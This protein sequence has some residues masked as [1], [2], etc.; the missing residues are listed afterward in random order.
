[1]NRLEMWGWNFMSKGVLAMQQ[2]FFEIGWRLCQQQLLETVADKGTKAAAAMKP[3]KMTES[4]ANMVMAKYK[5]TNTTTRD[6]IMAHVTGEPKTKAPSL[7][8]KKICQLINEKLVLNQR[9]YTREEIIA[10]FP[11]VRQSRLDTILATEFTKLPN[12]HYVTN[13]LD[14]LIMDMQKCIGSDLTVVNSKMLALNYTSNEIHLMIDQSDCFSV[15]DDTLFNSDS[16]T[17]KYATT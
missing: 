7:S 3:A 12:E 16:V 10:E 2:A 15:V 14:A 17:E 13:R 1:M 8:S 6:A 11:T 9:L 4:E 5:L